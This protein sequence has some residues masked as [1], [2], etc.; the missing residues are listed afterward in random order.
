MPSSRSYAPLPLRLIV[1][2]GFLYHGI[3]KLGAGHEAFLGMLRSFGLPMPEISSWV[4]AT[5]EVLGG[6]M[7][8]LGFRIRYAIP[9]LAATMVAALVKVHG[10]QGF[11]FIHQT[12]MTPEGPTFGMPGYEVNLLYLAILTALWFSGPGALALGDRDS[13]SAGAAP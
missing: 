2:V 8:L 5:V 6:V 11:S 4:V 7:V 9:F 10:P 1:A 12:G 3:P 13:A